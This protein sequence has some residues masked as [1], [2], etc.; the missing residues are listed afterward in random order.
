MQLK[1]VVCQVDVMNRGRCSQKMRPSVKYETWANT[2][3]TC[4]QPREGSLPSPWGTAEVIKFHFS[5]LF[6]FL[7]EASGNC[8]I[9]NLFYFIFYFIFINPHGVPLRWNLTNAQHN[10]PDYFSCSADL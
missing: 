6:W 2:C 7:L 5:H 1:F 8:S 3:A 9:S 10:P 4:Q